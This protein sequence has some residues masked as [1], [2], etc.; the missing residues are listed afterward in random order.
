M[1]LFCDELFDVFEEGAEKK[2]SSK[3]KKRRRDGGGGGGG[4]EQDREE[5]KKARVAEKS[6]LST[7]A[8][9]GG[10]SLAP[11]DMDDEPLLV[12]TV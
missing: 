3:A 6:D 1:A 12:E 8:V 2:A 7:S 9:V 11:E 4:S 10:A 5:Q